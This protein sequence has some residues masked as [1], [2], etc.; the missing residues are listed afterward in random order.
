MYS[1]QMSGLSAATQ[2]SAVVELVGR[3]RHG[4]R[5]G[6]H[7]KKTEVQFSDDYL[8]LAAHLILINAEQCVPAPAALT[9][10]VFK[11]R[12]LVTLLSEID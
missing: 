11:V 2:K 9:D 6:A 5:F 8:L 4:L 7:L 3:H 1:G 10:T 12:V